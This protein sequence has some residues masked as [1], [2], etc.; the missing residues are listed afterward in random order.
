MPLTTMG[1]TTAMAPAFRAAGVQREG[2]QRQ[3]LAEQPGRL[4]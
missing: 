1:W 3:E 2:A 4:T